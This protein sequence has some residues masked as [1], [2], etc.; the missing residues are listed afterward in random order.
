M[1][2]KQRGQ[3]GELLRFEERRGKQGSD[4]AGIQL[5]CEWTERLQSGNLQ[6]SEE[7]T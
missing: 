1:W 5:L 6:T 2:L 4:H 7:T 3:R